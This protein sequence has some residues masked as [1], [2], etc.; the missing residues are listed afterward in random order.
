MKNFVVIG[1][2]TAGWLTALYTKMFFPEDKVTVIESSEIGILGAGEATTPITV[3]LLDFLQIPTEELIRNTQ[4]TFKTGTKFTNWSKD[5]DF[6]HHSFILNYGDFHPFR[7]NLGVHNRVWNGPSI[8]EIIS[9]FRN[10]KRKEYDFHSIV[11]EKNK[12]FLLKKPQSEDTKTMNDFEIMA[13]YAINFDARE[14][15]KFLAK[16]G[17]DRGIYSIDG[18][19]KNFNTDSNG[20][21]IKIILEN[22]EIDCDFVFDCS[23]FHRLI[24][25]KFYNSEWK[26]Y[27]EHLPMKKA[28]PF[29]M[30]VDEENLPPYVES[31]AMDYGWSWKIPLQHRYGCGYVYDSDFISDDNAKKELDNFIGYEVDSPRTITFNPGSY[32]K[33]WIKNCLALG[34]SSGFIEPLEATSLMQMSKTLE[35]FFS[36]RQNIFSINE[37]YKEI[38]NAQVYNESEQILD[39]IYFHYMTNKE[40]N[41]FW[42]DFTKNNK[43]PDKLQEKIFLL[44]ESIL[45]PNDNLTVFSPWSYYVVA[46]GTG[47]LNLDN[48]KD[49][50]EKNYLYQKEILDFYDSIVNHQEINSDFF[51]DHSFA[52]KYLKG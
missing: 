6:Y 43:I 13:N 1:G 20:N 21:I 51:I 16:I 23:G 41:I 3:G 38:F 31:T 36:N 42:K 35:S 33:T 19:V 29:F 4:T 39:F 2:G 27:K 30:N 12:I 28:I 7:M 22:Q 11:S 9:M 5:N 24:I 15:A 40:N 8:Y 44:N 45:S 14:M 10:K 37:K 47:F 26:S 50:Y 49:I 34:L 46:H 52:I 17:F 18:T 48:I 25:G 32:K